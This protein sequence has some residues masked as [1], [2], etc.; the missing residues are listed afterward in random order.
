MS[1]TSRFA[2]TVL[3]LGGLLQLGCTGVGSTTSGLDAAL[4][5]LPADASS[6]L[7]GNAVI[8]EVINNVTAGD[9]TPYTV[10]LD[11]LIDGTPQTLTAL[12]GVATK[13]VLVSCATEVR[14]ITERWLDAKGRVVGGRDYSN[15][16]ANSF[17]P[18]TFGCGNTLLWRLSATAVQ[19]QVL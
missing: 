14:S 16:D 6:I 15:V 11:I 2:L 3:C 8:L 1:R 5:A 13:Y 7:T 17:L 19:T 9:G 4:A 10:E 12:P 18:G